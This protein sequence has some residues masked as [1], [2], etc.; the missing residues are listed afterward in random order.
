MWDSHM[1]GHADKTWLAPKVADQKRIWKAAAVVKPAVLD[2]GRVVAVWG[3]KKKGK[4]IEFEVEPLTG[5]SK[6]RH[7]AAVKRETRE[8][9]LH[10]DL[11]PSEV[12]IAK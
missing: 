10:Y 2:R 11:E 12:T 6:T 4:R 1:M 7:L 9:A 3:Q 5:W 8:A